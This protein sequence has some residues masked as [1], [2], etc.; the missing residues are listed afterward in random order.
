[1][2]CLL[3]LIDKNTRVNARTQPHTHSHIRTNGTVLTEPSDSQ[4][5][6]SHRGSYGPPLNFEF[7]IIIDDA[8]RKGRFI[9]GLHW[10]QAA[11]EKYSGREQM[12]F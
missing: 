10:Q 12:H 1:M 9:P 5:V 7:H 6:A 4:S 8:A 11:E 3:P 2:A